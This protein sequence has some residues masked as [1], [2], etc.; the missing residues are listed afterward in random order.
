MSKVKTILFVCTGNS[1][2]SVM[3]EGLAKKYLREKG[4]NNIRVISAGV[5]AIDGMPPTENTLEVMKKE[6]VDVSAHKTAI[7]T[8]EMIRTADIILVMEEFHKEE[9]LDRDPSAKDKTFLLKTFKR[10]AGNKHPD[11]VDV[12]DPIGRP[13]KDYEHTLKTIKGEIE[14][15]IKFL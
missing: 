2:R 5:S 15:I 10:D 4:K 12:L 9:I 3:A 6:G 7:L 14:R 8:D 11:G 1:C 13:L